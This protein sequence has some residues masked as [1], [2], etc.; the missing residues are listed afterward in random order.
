MNTLKVW[1]N[2]QHP[3]LE[4]NN[5]KGLKH[6]AHRSSS[7]TLTPSAFLSPFHHFSAFSCSCFA[8]IR[9]DPLAVRPSCARRA[10]GETLARPA[11][12]AFQFPRNQ[13]TRQ[14]LPAQA[15]AA[16]GGLDRL[17]LLTHDRA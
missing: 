6:F 17:P 14:H 10:A 9:S 4:Q 7:Q 1:I 15:S 16:A 5:K 13:Q 11:A 2:P 12:A 3:G 8:P